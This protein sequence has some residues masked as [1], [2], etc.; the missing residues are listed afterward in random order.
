MHGKYYT[1]SWTLLNSISHFLETILLVHFFSFYE[2]IIPI[3]KSQIKTICLNYSTIEW[4]LKLI[5][6]NYTWYMW[7]A[8]RL[9]NGMTQFHIFKWNPKWQ[10][11][12]YYMF[13]KSEKFSTAYCASLHL[14]KNCRFDNATN[15][16][17]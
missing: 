14:S 17:K 11:N 16:G 8:S 7:Y 13:K 3:F 15:L 12:M 10:H 9:K 2:L 1:F 5:F 4:K 6:E